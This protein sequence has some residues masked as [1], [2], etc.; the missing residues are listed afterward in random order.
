MKINEIKPAQWKSLLR[1]ISNRKFTLV[2][3]DDLIMVN[4]VMLNTYLVN[5]LY[6]HCIELIQEYLDNEQHECTDIEKY[7]NKV[8]S[9]NNNLTISEFYS[10]KIINLFGDYDEFGSIDLYIQHEISIIPKEIID[11]SMF[12]ILLEETEPRLIVST[13]YSSCLLEK[14]ID[15]CTENRINPY[16]ADILE[17]DSS[18]GFT[19]YCRERLNNIYQWKEGYRW[20]GKHN[21]ALFLNI[22]GNFVARNLSISNLCI[23]EDDWVKM[24]CK[25]VVSIQ[26][27]GNTPIVTHLSDSYLLVLGTSLPSWAFRFLWFTLNNP[28]LKN[29]VDMAS[30]I[31]V[32][33]EPHNEHVKRFIT[34]Y[35]S[36]II[37]ADET[38]QFL[39]QFTNRW[40][41][42]PDY[43]RFKEKVA[44][45]KPSKEHIFVSY[46]SEDR[47]ILEEYL[48]P[49]L[50][51]LQAR[52]GYTFWYDKRSLKGGDDWDACIKDAIKNANCFIPFLTSNTKEMSHSEAA[53]YLQIEWREALQKNKSLSKDR[54]F[55]TPRFI[56]PITIGGKS[57]LL[58]H[59]SGFQSIDIED[60]E[61]DETIL[62]ELE[63]IINESKI[64]Q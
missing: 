19:T 16:V 14:F 39:I 3:G 52:N 47:Q 42:W 59:F 38:A 8:F 5:K 51:K 50:E 63:K 55:G 12:T 62:S 21:E 41:E 45:R 32:R 6:A 25:W 34:S 46:L 28:L 40:K 9:I 13:C 10:Q 37:S 30:S 58:G 56:F 53:R 26:T 2:V 7:A 49:I 31:S 1:Q 57:M 20:E 11:I 54:K 36:L 22:G 43:I 61:S 60:T 23:T 29:N 17:G 24:I 48:I 33:P 35:K 15:Y 64:Y 27:Y 44:Q 4:G 18:G